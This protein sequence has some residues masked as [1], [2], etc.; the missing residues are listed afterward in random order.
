[1]GRGDIPDVCF[2]RRFDSL[3]SK[4]TSPFSFST[5]SKKTSNRTP[6]NSNSFLPEF[7]AGLIRTWWKHSAS[8]T[9]LSSFKPNFHLSKAIKRTVNR[10][11][12]NSNSYRSEFY[13]ILIRTWWKPVTAAKIQNRFSFTRECKKTLNRTPWKFN[14]FLVEF[15]SYLPEFTKILVRTSWKRTSV[16]N[17]QNHVNYLNLKSILCFYSGQKIV[18]FFGSKIRTPWKAESFLV[19]SK[20]YSTEK[21]M[22]LI[23][24]QWKSIRTTWKAAI[25]FKG[26]LSNLGVSISTSIYINKGSINY[27]RI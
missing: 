24:T 25:D 10:T 20:S 22:P 4:T 23:R 11:P 9:V 21:K 8:S 13:T 17:I 19:E 12:W 16:S 27:G 26:Y 14:S 6:W 1:M 5:E 15:N 3:F 2:K 18:A 7:S